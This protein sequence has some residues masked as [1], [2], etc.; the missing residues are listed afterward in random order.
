MND[1]VFYINDV[2]QI[3]CGYIYIYKIYRTMY[4]T[5]YRNVCKSSQLSRSNNHMISHHGIYTSNQYCTDAQ[6]VIIRYET[7]C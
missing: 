6:H 3:A 5:Y 4:N 7:Y 2:L 1:N